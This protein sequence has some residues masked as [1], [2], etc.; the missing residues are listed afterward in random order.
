MAIAYVHQNRTTSRILLTVDVPG[1]VADAVTVAVAVTV[2][3][4][5]A[6]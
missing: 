3:V 4:R 6:V 5:G 2:D 1:A